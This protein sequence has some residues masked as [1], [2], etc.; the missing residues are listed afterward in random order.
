M[1]KVT[2][3][4]TPFCPYCIQA[5]DFFKENKIEYTDIDASSEKHRQNLIN[6]TGQFGV[7]VIIIE[8]EDD[9]KE[10]VIGFDQGRL[11]EVLG[12]K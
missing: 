9:K 11:E 12:I 6:K 10:T 3:Y 7:P 1:T 5:K 4:S 2:I 8:R